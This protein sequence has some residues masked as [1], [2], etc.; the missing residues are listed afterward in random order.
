MSSTN[1]PLLKSLV[2]VDL[3]THAQQYEMKQSSQS[4]IFYWLVY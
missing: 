4:V 2:E 1:V 3:F